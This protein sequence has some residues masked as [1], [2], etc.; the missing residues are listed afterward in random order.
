MLMDSMATR[1]LWAAMIGFLLGVFVRSLAPFGLTH[2]LLLLALAAA[3]IA[4]ARAGALGRSAGLAAAVF[5]VALALGG[6]RMHAAI[7]V[8]DPVLAA[9]LGGSVSLTGAVAEDPDARDGSVRVILDVARLN[10]TTSAAVSARVLAAAAPG[11]DIAYGDRV[12]VSG[13]LA[14][15][16]PFDTGPGRSFDYPGYLATRGVLFEISRAKIEQTEARG[17]GNPI[18]AAAIR[19]KHAYI[20]GTEAVLPEPYAGL[21]GGI[22]VGDKR[23]VGPEL[24]VLFQKVSLSHMLV[25]SGYNITIVAAVALALLGRLPLAAR[26]S[27]AGAAVVFFVLAA[28]GAASAVRAASMALIALYARAAGRQYDALRILVAVC[29]AMVAWNPY[30]LAFDPGFQLS[31]L[32]TVGLIVLSP[33]SMQLFGWLPERFGLREI[34]ATSTATQLTVLPLVLWQS[35]VLSVAGLPANLLAL[36]AVPGAMFASVLAAAGGML[37]GSW[38]LPLAAPA[39][40]LL[41]YIIGVVRVFAALPFAAVSIPAFGGWVLVPAYAL[42]ASVAWR[43]RTKTAA[44]DAAAVGER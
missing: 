43:F 36:L 1:I 35:G 33:V 37:L 17:A 7:L 38:A 41:A 21:A 11:S 31:A 25:L 9:R 18:V 30:L 23:S 4:L 3:A 14:H 40:I 24:A 20:A 13:T 42:L 29:V 27:G 22:V 15:P 44:A 6:A 16:R 34:A 28:G 19:V 5:F 32:A 26:T 10:G 39:Y 2:A 8:P 12:I